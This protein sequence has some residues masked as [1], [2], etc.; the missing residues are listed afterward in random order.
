MGGFCWNRERV[1]LTRCG[2]GW[3]KQL[4]TMLIQIGMDMSSFVFVMM[5]LIISFSAGFF[6]LHGRITDPGPSAYQY[7]GH[8]LTRT[9]L[10]SVLGDFDVTELQSPIE[11]TSA[12][13]SNIS[14]VFFFLLVMGVGVVGMVNLSKT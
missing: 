8:T 13:L 9:F 3:E 7:L 12:A 5:V 6:C 2:A 4:V 1:C 11:E 10:M 14:Y